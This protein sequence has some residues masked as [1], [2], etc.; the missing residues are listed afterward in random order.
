MASFHFT[1]NPY[2]LRIPRSESYA[3]DLSNPR[4]DGDRLKLRYLDTMQ[5]RLDRELGGNWIG[6]SILAI[7]CARKYLNWLPVSADRGGK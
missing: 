3:Y 2:A 5:V 6:N 4:L 7:P 1:C